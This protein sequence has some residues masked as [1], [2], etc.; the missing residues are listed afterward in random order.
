M[1][2]IADWTAEQAWAAVYV[3]ILYDNAQ[4]L[5]PMQRPSVK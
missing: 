1:S 3:V 2:F 4:Y 5:C